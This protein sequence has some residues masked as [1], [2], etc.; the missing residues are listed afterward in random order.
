MSG[1]FLHKLTSHILMSSLTPSEVY[2]VK[3]DDYPWWPATVRFVSCC[4]VKVSPSQ[5]IISQGNTYDKGTSHDPTDKSVMV[6]FLELD[7]K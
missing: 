3:V 2:W 1:L 7:V 4:N 6:H 5:H